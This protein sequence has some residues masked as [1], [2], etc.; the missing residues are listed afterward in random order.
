MKMYRSPVRIVGPLLVMVTASLVTGCSGGYG[1]REQGAL[2]GAGVGAGTG[3]VVGGRLGN[4]GAGAAIGAGTGAVVGGIVGDSLDSNEDRHQI[5][6]EILQRQRDEMARQKRELEDIKR[7]QY[8]ND[9]FRRYEQPAVGAVVESE[10]VVGE[11]AEF[12]SDVAP[13]PGDDLRY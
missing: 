8:H 10:P 2:I 4:A 3:S 5:Q 6:E 11:G 7:Q 13:A 9:S 12:S 1:K